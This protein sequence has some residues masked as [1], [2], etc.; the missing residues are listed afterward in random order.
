M[1][2]EEVKKAIELLA[3]YCGSRTCRDCQLHIDKAGCL[4]DC[5]YPYQWA[6]I[7]KEAEND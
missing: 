5:G 1:S 6:E 4:C 3:E 7:M 2:N